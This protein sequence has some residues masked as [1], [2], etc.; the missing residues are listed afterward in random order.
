MK[1][2]NDT[3]MRKQQTKKESNEEH[4]TNERKIGRRAEH[5]QQRKSK[6]REGQTKYCKKGTKERWNQQKNERTIRTN[7]LTN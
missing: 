3:G 1:G 2:T 7:E 4:Q 6:R 5:K